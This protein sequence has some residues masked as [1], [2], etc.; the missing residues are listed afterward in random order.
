MKNNILITGHK[1]FLGCH[2]FNFLKRHNEYKLTGRDIDIYTDKRNY[3]NTRKTKN[4]FNN[5]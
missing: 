5:F 3:K 4:K 1:G 2:L